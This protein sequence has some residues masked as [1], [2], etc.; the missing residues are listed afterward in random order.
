MTLSFG[1]T[2]SRNES[3]TRWATGRIATPRSASSTSR[4][5]SGAVYHCT[6]CSQSSSVSSVATDAILRASSSEISPHSTATV[7]SGRASSRSTR[8]AARWSVRCSRPSPR[9]M[10]RAERQPQDD[11][12]SAIT[13]R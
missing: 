4:A 6:I 11:A 9:V 5:K 2:T 7:V 1:E 3:I 8:S 12:R 10:S 13:V